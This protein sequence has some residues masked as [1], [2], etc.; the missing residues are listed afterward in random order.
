[1]EKTTTNKLIKKYL[2]KGFEELKPRVA[3]WEKQ[4]QPK[5]QLLLFDFNKKPSQ[6]S[7][8]EDTE[9]SYSTEKE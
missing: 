8:L 4:K 2:R 1:L 3:E 9:F 7:M 6:S 5:N